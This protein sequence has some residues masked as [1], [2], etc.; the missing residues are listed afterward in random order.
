MQDN[1]FGG[2]NPFLKKNVENSINVEAEE[3]K[4]EEKNKNDNPILENTQHQVAPKKSNSLVESIQNRVV[5]LQQQ[6]KLY[7][8]KDYS[9]G[10]ALQ[11]AWLQILQTKDK[12]GA[13]ALNVCTK[14]SVANALLDMA[15]MGQNPAKT[16]GYFIVYGDQLTW[17]P[18]YFGKCASL[19]RVKGIDTEPIGT[20]IYEGDEVVLAHNELGEEIIQEHKTTWENKLQGKIIGA[21]ATVYCKGI[22]RSAV[23]TRAEIDESWNAQKLIKN[24][25]VNDGETKTK[26]IG[27]FCKRTVINR[28]V[29]MI[30]KTSNDEDLLAETILQNEEKH[31]DFNQ[32]Q[33]T[34]YASVEE[35][36]ESVELNVASSEPIEMSYDD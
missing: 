5:A 21:Y 23:M 12:N 31:Y 11:T 33:E 34:K 14:E 27:E 4:A 19:K 17:F 18:S 16:Q 9:V 2:T 3:I 26:F 7:L 36:Q 35:V 6:N 24:Q 13:L 10:N 32:N 15:I 8:P 29:K 1:L 28:V 20:L 22:K 25:K 30:L